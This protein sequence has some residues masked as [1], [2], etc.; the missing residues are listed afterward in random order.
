MLRDYA[1]LVIFS[2]GLLVGVQVPGFVDQYA[3]R[4]SA[5][6][7]EAQRNFSGFRATANQYF[8]GSVAAL[9]SHH[10]SSNDRVFVDEAKTI[11][12][13]QDRL[14]ALA[15]EVGAL[16]G[17]LVKQIIHVATSADREI[18]SETTTAYSYTVPLAPAAIVCGVTAG[19][20]AALFVEA[21]LIGILR[22]LSILWHGTH[23]SSK[24]A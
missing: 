13:L 9:I 2:L 7:V 11:Q 8:N 22:L 19:F 1:R 21:L 12:A 4:V 23:R 14:A 10:L 20:A 16:E 18:L 15:A 17:P 24:A 6:Y 5:H 3:K